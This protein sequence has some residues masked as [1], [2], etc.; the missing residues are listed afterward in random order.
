MGTDCC[1]DGTWDCAGDGHG[2]S[3]DKA[4]GGVMLR[5]TT[6]AASDA[7]AHT[8]GGALLGELTTG[9]LLPR[10]L[11]LTYY[12]RA[13][14]MFDAYYGVSGGASTGG[15]T[16]PV[17]LV[18]GDPLLLNASRKG[19]AFSVVVIA[20]LFGLLFTAAFAGASWVAVQNAMRSAGLDDTQDTGAY[21]K[22]KKLRR[23]NKG[24]GGT[25]AGTAQSMESTQP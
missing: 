24:E 9:V 10:D 18:L 23:K 22:V 14:R 15:T 19:R 17:F 2:L 21:R 8:G 12:A 13:A 1:S 3:D 7:D 4:L 6:S 25:Q 11:S 20:G 5:D 16:G